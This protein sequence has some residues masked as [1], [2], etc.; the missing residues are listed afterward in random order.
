MAEICAFCEHAILT[1]MQV[2]LTMIVRNEAAVIERCLRSIR[3]WVDAFAIVDTGSED[4]T[5]DLARKCLDGVPGQVEHRKWEGMAPNRNQALELARAQNCSHMLML[6]ADDEWIADD[7]FA[8]PE[9]DDDAYL[10]ALE[11]EGPMGVTRWYRPGLMKCASP[12]R[13]EGIAHE[14]LVG[15]A[16]RSRLEKAK[17]L[18]HP[19]GHRRSTEGIGKYRRIAR[20]LESELER[21]PTDLHNRFYLAQSYR[22]CGEYEK[23]LVHYRIRASKP[24]G[25]EEERWYALYQVACMLEKTSAPFSEVV[26][27][28]Q[29]AYER[30]PHRGEPLVAAAGYCRRNKRPELAAMFAAT[31]SLILPISQEILFVDQSVHWRALDELATAAFE[32]GRIDLALEMFLKLQQRDD[33]P[34]HQRDRIESDIKDVAEAARRLATESAR[35]S[36]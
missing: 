17:I 13:Y 20:L 25:W 33:V 35:K 7:D 30:N 29:R 2:C 27:A 12:C 9:S 24:G 22:D 4:E 19:D 10:V 6:D 36:S 34:E 16:A 18:S 31:A 3:P 8:W 14:R 23:A 1:D 21:D 5:L 11:A 26:A 32:I 28:Y 15:V